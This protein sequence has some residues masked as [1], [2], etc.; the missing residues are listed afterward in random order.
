MDDLKYQVDLLTALNEKL[1]KSE[2]IFRQI[3]E[4]SGNVYLYYDYN[5]REVRVDFIGPWDVL[6]GEKITNSPYDESYMLNLLLDEDQDAFR[7]KIL[8]MERDKST[9]ASLEVHSKTRK[10]SFKVEAIATYDS[11]GNIYDKLVTFIDTTKTKARNDELHYMAYYDTLTGLCNRNRFV[12]ILRDFCVKAEEEKTS[13]EVL[14]LDIDDFKKINDTIGLVMGDELVQELSMYLKTYESEDVQIGRFG[15]D[16]FVMAI[17]N[18]C[19]QK[20]ADNIYRGIR[21]KLH[22]PFVLSNRQNVEFTISAGVAEFP[23]AGETATE[24][25]KNAELV[26]YSAKE[27]GRNQIE[28]F[29]PDI[30]SKHI[31]DMSIEKQLKTAVANSDFTLYFQ[32]QFSSENGKLRGV[33]VLF[34]WPAVNGGFISAP[35]EIIPIAEKNGLIVPIGEWI[36]KEAMR[37]YSEFR[38]K[39]HFPMT[40]SVNISPVQ[41]LKENFTE[42]IQNLILIYEISPEMLEIELTEDAFINDYDEV[43]SR[44]NILRKMGVKVSLDDFGTGYSSLT[45]FKKLPVDTLKLDKSVIDSMLSDEFTGYIAKSVINMCKHFSIETIAEGVESKEQLLYLQKLN[46]DYIQ[47]FLLGKPMPRNEFEKVIIRQLP[48]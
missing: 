16:M 10:Y 17:Y 36:L 39:Y 14:L 30:L 1:M 34:R 2:H 40:L 31:K 7:E 6:T 37:V 42:V 41:I 23:D 48:G 43:V 20:T 32:P 5:D 35:E 19:N 13:V 28:F 33:E 38:A 29:E 46:C 47:G 24:L 9:S 44:I 25:I 8:Y 12:E 27:H 45:L 4:S 3:A 18:P 15:S 26:L 21:D 11:E 22:N